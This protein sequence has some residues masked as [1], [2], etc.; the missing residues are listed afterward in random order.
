MGGSPAVAGSMAAWLVTVSDRQ[1]DS[2][3]ADG[4][5]WPSP[6]FPRS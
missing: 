4:L 5:A 6:G 3:E 1:A 2:L